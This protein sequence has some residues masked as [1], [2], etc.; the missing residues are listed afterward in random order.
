[1][2]QWRSNVCV[3][4]ALLLAACGPVSDDVSAERPMQPA[5][6]ERAASPANASKTAVGTQI[7][8]LGDSL[9]AGYNLAA[10]DA[11][12]EQ[13]EARLR[14]EGHEIS[15]V[16]AAVSGD[17]TRGG[18]E[19]YDWS[20]K[21]AEPDVLVVALGANDFLGGI[22]V[23]QAR[24]NL[25]SIIRRAQADQICVALVGIAVRVPGSEDAREQAFAEVYPELAR[26]Y[27]VPLY[28]D[29]L[30]GLA[31]GAGLLQ[32]DGLHPTE[33]GVEVMAAPLG[34]FLS[35]QLSEW[36]DACGRP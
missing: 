7:V 17:T 13:L 36:G 19:R 6:E 29:M 25:A 21:S 1:M 4:I 23:G 24:D 5:A 30:A 32:A 18:L 16:N 12:P 2:I 20:V 35:A 27:D 15:V 9:M 11:L 8:F 3:S 10:G 14:A 33:R 34:E 26:E 31:D 28:P 22:S